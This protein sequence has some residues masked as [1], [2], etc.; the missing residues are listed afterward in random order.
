[1]PRTREV[2]LVAGEEEQHPE[3]EVREE[4]DEVVRLGEPE[5][6][7]PDDDAEED[8]DHDDRHRQEA[9][10]QRRG[11]RGD[12]RHGDDREEV[13]RVDPDQERVALREGDA[14][15]GSPVT[16]VRAKGLLGAQSTTRQETARGT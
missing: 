7:G 16:G 6:V 12:R 14:H 4:L 10:Q 9:A 3:A 13:A 5:H 15:L 1:M 2:D 11:Q 8:L